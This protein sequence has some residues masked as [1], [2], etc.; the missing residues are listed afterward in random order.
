MANVWN[1]YVVC[2]QRLHPRKKVY[3]PSE[4]V[5]GCLRSRVHVHYVIRGALSRAATGT[6]RT[7]YT[8]TGTYYLVTRHVWYRYVLPKYTEYKPYQPNISFLPASKRCLS[9]SHTGSYQACRTRRRNTQCIDACGKHNPE[10]D[11][12]MLVL[13]KATTGMLLQYR[14]SLLHRYGYPRVCHC[15]S[16]HNEIPFFNKDGNTAPLPTFLKFL[17]VE[18]LQQ[19]KK[20]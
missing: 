18:V 3:L 4:V 1:R 11:S 13:E 9:N 10:T 12:T 7:G 8:I 15:T 2:H 17:C 20:H 6:L 19:N 14:K 16:S 5:V